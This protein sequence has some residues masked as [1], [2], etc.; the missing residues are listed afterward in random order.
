MIPNFG[1]I[2]VCVIIAIVR[3]LQLLSGVIRKI[4]KTIPSLQKKVTLRKKQVL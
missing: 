1:L 2:M 4:S 3:E